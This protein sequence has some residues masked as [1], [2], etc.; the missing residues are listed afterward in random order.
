M[1]KSL[2]SLRFFFALM[3]F[4]HHSALNLLVFGAFPVSFFF[5]LSGFVLMMGYGG[6]ISSMS[7][8]DFTLK[9]ILRVYPTHIL[10]LFIAL[11]VSA[12][13]SYPIDWYNTLPSFFLI[14]AWIPLQEIYFAGNSVAWYVSDIVFC[15]LMFPLLVKVMK[16]NP[17]VSIVIVVI[18]YLI[19]CFLIPSEYHHAFLYINPFFRVVDFMIG[20]WLCLI[21][22][23][24]FWIKVKDKMLKLGG[25][26]KTLCE[27]VPII[28]SFIAILI[29]IKYEN[30]FS[31]AVLWWVP[32][33]V[34][35][36]IYSSLDSSPGLV[37]KL[38]QLKP[39]IVLGSISYAFYM[40]HRSILMVNNYLMN[41]TPINYVLD[42]LI[43][44]IVLIV[45]SYLVTYYF[46]PLF[47]KRRK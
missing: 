15:Y 32:S 27:S 31:Y 36:I 11:F 33:L 25:W 3:I 7:Y 46:E 18:C 16:W 5:I 13:I 1:I 39:L 28:I 17:S 24:D 8:G 40:L 9:R 47:K 26:G 4:L 19:G 20:M 43:V 23:Q 6:R 30:A 44:L 45:L 12:I 14:Q 10:C 22:Q 41:I 2:Q 37:L 29:S 38:L 34:F 21:L 42:G 35:I